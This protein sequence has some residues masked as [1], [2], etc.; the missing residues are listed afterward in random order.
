MRMEKKHYT[1]TGAQGAAD[2]IV[3]W[4]VEVGQLENVQVLGGD[5]T[6]SMTGWDGRAIHLIEVGK[7]EKVVWDNCLLHTNELGLR[8]VIKKL[9]METSGQNSFTGENG[10]CLF[11]CLRLMS[12][13]KLLLLVRTSLIFQ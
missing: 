2:V 12:S 8:H 4:F 11:T 10:S 6:D 5:S 3:Q 1:L 7:S 13:L 9:G